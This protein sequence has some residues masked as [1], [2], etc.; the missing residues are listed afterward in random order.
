M[1]TTDN[2]PKVNVLALAADPLHYSQTVMMESALGVLSCLATVCGCRGCEGVLVGG[3][4]SD[5][6]VMKE[7]VSHLKPWLTRDNWKSHPAHKQSLVWCVRHVPHPHLSPHLDS[8]LP[9]TLLFLDDHDD[10]HKVLGLTTATH[11]IKNVVR[12]YCLSF[13]SLCRGNSLFKRTPPSSV[14]MDV[15]KYCT[16]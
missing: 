8:L 9:P 6:G 5:S 13:S 12:F 11:I 14:G 2:L 4:D 16:R 10:Y 15:L 1:L 7:A 3:D